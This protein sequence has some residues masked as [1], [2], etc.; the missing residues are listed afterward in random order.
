MTSPLGALDSQLYETLL[1]S[2]CIYLLGKAENSS[3][4]EELGLYSVE[5]GLV[6]QLNVFC[7]KAG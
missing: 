6:G 5:I 3:G 4:S 7:S 1:S 2:F